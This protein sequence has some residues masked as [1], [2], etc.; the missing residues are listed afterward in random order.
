MDVCLLILLIFFFLEIF[1][2][3]VDYFKE[4][5]KSE[6]WGFHCSENSGPSLVDCNAI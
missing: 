6:I 4:H 1:L 3:Y 2:L 5:T